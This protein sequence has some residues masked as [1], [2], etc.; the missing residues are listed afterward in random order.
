MGQG[1]YGFGETFPGNHV[2]QRPCVSS[3]RLLLEICEA[4]ALGSNDL[5]WLVAEEMLPP[6]RYEPREERCE[7]PGDSGGGSQEWWRSGRPRGRGQMPRGGLLPRESR[8]H[9]GSTATADGCAPQGIGGNIPESLKGKHCGD[10]AAW[11]RR[12]CQGGRVSR[13]GG[14][15]VERPFERTACIPSLLRTLR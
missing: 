2:E 13:D 7:G 14:P 11:E 6:L 4:S 9:G 3:A 12:D 10:G 1:S 5:F 8:A 15:G